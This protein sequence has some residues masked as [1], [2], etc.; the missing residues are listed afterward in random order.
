MAKLRVCYPHNFKRLL[1]FSPKNSSF[2]GVLGPSVQEGY[3]LATRMILT[4]YKNIT[5]QIQ[6]DNLGVGEYKD[7][8]NRYDG[9]LG[10][11][12]MNQSDLM[13]QLSPYPLAIENVTQG[14][15]VLETGLNFAAGYDESQVQGS[16]QVLNTIKAF[17]LSV[18]LLCIIT[19]VTMSIFLTLEESF[20][21]SVRKFIGARVKISHGYRYQVISQCFRRGRINDRRMTSR[22]LFMS[23]AVHSLL[24]IHYF[25]SDAKAERVVIKDPIIMKSYDD[26]IER[27]VLPVFPQGMSYNLFFKSTEAKPFRRR[28]WKYAVESYG[29]GSL[30]MDLS[31]FSFMVMALGIIQQKAVLIIG[32]DLVQ[33]LKSSGCSLAGRSPDV[34]LDAIPILKDPKG[35]RKILTHF[36]AGAQE[37]DRVL[38]FV[39]KSKLELALPQFLVHV[40]RDPREN[41]FSQGVLYGE[42]GDR[43]L[44]SSAMKTLRRLIELGFAIQKKIVLD[45]TSMY[46][47]DKNIEKLLGKPIR[48]RQYLV[49][50]CKRKS[51][52]KPTISCAS[53]ELEHMKSLF[54]LV[55]G[56]YCVLLIILV[57]E[58]IRG[59]KRLAYRRRCAPGRR[60]K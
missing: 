20:Y 16:I 11:L 55:A 6:A 56:I 19:C 26:I 8:L 18:W 17:P 45:E 47:N 43:Q 35:L 37:A 60:E 44:L 38:E 30:Y 40:T 42:N 13:M 5:V 54:K 28:L 12:Q 36:G 10:Q 51:I 14:M 4:Q 46:E 59:H 52:E 57:V 22:I 25:N 2:S 39:K 21:Q 27:K 3:D 53:I 48:G 1:E 49:E 9:C 7:E 29:E 58:W 32:E 34:T 31:P 24:V 33:S 23:A 50:K 15:I 41:T